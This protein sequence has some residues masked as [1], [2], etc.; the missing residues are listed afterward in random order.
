VV[1]EH[2]PSSLGGTFTFLKGSHVTDRLVV[3]SEVRGGSAYEGLFAA[4]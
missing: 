1:L 2:R 4:D 3:V